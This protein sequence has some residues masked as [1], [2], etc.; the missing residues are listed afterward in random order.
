[1]KF[2]KKALIFAA[3]LFLIP[4]VIIVAL[5]SYLGFTDLLTSF[6]PTTLLMGGIIVLF[7][8]YFKNTMGPKDIPNGLPG[9]ATVISSRQGNQRMKRGAYEFY[10]LILDVNVVASSGET[11]QTQM[12]EMVSIVQVGSF[13]P[14]A[15]FAIKY[16]PTNRNNITFD[17]TEN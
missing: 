2:N 4:V 11:W 8:F 10:Q 3:V 6:L 17:R 12:K 7:M 16:D 1:M 14:G 15:S 5:S 9:R 13:L